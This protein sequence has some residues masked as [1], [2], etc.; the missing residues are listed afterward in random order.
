MQREAERVNRIIKDLLAYSR[1]AGEEA[2]PVDLGVLVEDTM[3][4]LR[5]LSVM[6]GVR[7]EVHADDDVPEVEATRDR[8]SQVVVNLALNAAEAMV[9]EGRLRIT[10]TSADE[11]A[12]AVLRFEDDGPG[13]DEEVIG[14][15]FDPFVTTKPEHEGTG[16]GLAVCQGIVE[17]F[18]GVIQARNAPGGGAVFEVLLPAAGEPDRTEAG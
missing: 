9:G 7:V 17:G 3:A 12:T 18:G 10:M 16:L 4:V 2:E 13:I 11:G 8:I 6:K 1:P 5:P 15:L 14:N